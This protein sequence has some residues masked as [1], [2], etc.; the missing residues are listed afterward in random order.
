[1]SFGG[2]LG[3][4]GRW[5]AAGS[6]FGPWGTAI[7]TGLGFLFGG[8][9]PNDG[10]AQ[11]MQQ[12]MLASQNEANRLQ[13]FQ[14]LLGGM[15]KGPHNAPQQQGMSTWD[16]VGVAGGA[17]GDMISSIMRARGER[18]MREEEMRRWQIMEDD[19]AA[20]GNLLGQWMM[21]NQRN[22]YPK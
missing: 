11:M 1:M 17:I 6:S 15:G 12:R 20:A 8:G 14:Q 18:Q 7:G 22:P 13:G 21:N 2:R 4:A 5:G 16:K 10:K 19:R 9:G 3:N